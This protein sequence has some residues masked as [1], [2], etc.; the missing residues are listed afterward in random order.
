MLQKIIH[1]YFYLISKIKTHSIGSHKRSSLIGF[2]ADN[3]SQGVVQ[4]VS[5]S[6]IAHDQS[7]SRLINAKLDLVANS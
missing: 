7:S 4:N 6:V 5:S 1:L 3:L 2:L